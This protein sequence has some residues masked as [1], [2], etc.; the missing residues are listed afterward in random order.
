MKSKMMKIRNLTMAVAIIALATSCGNDDSDPVVASSNF[1]VTIENV[2]TPQPFFASGI[3][4]TPVGATAPGPL[5][6]GDAYEFTINAGPNVTPGD[7]GT[8]L[9]FALMMVQSNDLFYA[10]GEE[11]IALYANGVAVGSGGAVDVTSQISL[12]DAGTEVNEATG[13]PNQKP[14]QSADDQGMD[15]NGNVTLIANNTDV[16]GNVLPATADVIKVTIEATADSEFKVRIEN[17]SSMTTISTLS[18]TA[19]VPL[20]PGVFVIHTASSPLFVAGEAAASSGLAASMSGIEDIAE[21]GVTTALTADAAAKTGLIVPMSPG[22][23]AV[24]TGSAVLFANGSADFG[25]GME[26][27]AEDGTPMILAASLAAKAN[28]SSSAAFNTPVGAN[29]P[30]AIGPGGS[31]E[32]SFEASPGDKLSLATMFVQSNDW[33]YSFNDAGLDLFSGDV[34]VSGDVTSSII[35]YDAGTEVDEVPGAGLNQVIR[36]GTLN[37]GAADANT[38]VRV[39]S[40]AAIPSTSSVIKVTISNQ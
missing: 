33:F 22:A 10:P 3:F 17:V 39:V 34:A 30:S 1:T 40:G 14:Q 20:S 31:Y 23:Y 35:L 21:D 32:F 26:G 18:G 5:F 11:G 38:N 6:P 36:Q 2:V 7:G 25:E 13:G 15:E 29:A 19:A 8:R 28:V 4:N 27:V 9:S 37:T 16:F 12:W 24:H